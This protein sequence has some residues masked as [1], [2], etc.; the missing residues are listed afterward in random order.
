MHAQY[1][2]K[3]VCVAAQ[4]LAQ[5]CHLPKKDICMYAMHVPSTDLANSKS[6]HSGHTEPTLDKIWLQYHTRKTKLR[7]SN[8]AIFHMLG[9]ID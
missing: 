4:S 5:T 8:L 1:S 7:Y 6:H 2:Q 9:L 3:T